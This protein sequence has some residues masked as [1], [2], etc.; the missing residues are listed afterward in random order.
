M[1]GIDHALMWF[2]VSRKLGDGV[3][4]PLLANAAYY[5]KAAGSVTVQIYNA[6]AYEDRERSLGTLPQGY[7]PSDVVHANGSADRGAI[8]LL[9]NSNG[10]TYV[11]VDPG[12]EVIIYR[13]VSGAM[14][15]QVTFPCA[16]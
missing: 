4:H 7:R 9:V 2:S 8:G 10:S 12:G 6:T 5:T 11:R 14:T 1:G 13:G 3:W 16:P 15:G